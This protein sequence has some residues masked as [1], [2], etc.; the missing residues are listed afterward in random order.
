MLGIAFFNS[1]NNAFPSRAYL[2]S[3]AI[4]VAAEDDHDDIDFFESAIKGNETG[5]STFSFRVITKRKIVP[6]ILPF[7]MCLN[8]NN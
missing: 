8:L 6:C 3:T 4:V 2:R 7:I 5:V 1:L